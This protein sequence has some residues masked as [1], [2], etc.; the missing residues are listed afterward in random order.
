MKT[1][2]ILTILVLG[3]A[4][5]TYLGIARAGILFTPGY[6]PVEYC[7]DKVVP[8]SENA[9]SHLGCQGGARAFDFEQSVDSR[10]SELKARVAKL[11][12]ALEQERTDYDTVMKKLTNAEKSIGDLKCQLAAAKVSG[13]VCDEPES[14]GK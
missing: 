8:I 13:V 1:R 7:A 3:I 12:G 9:D 4:L 2:I 5:G 10:T 11:E 14:Q 6:Q